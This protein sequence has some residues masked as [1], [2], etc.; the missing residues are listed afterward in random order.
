[1]AGKKD[2][3][4]SARIAEL[5]NDLQ[6]TRADFENYRKQMDARNAQTATYARL[7]I[8]KKFLPLLD[9]MARAIAVTPDLKPLEK[10]LEKT[11]KDLGL[12]KID[13]KP[14]TPFNPDLHDAVMMN[15]GEGDQ[16]VVEE[17]LRDG[18]L[19]EGETLRPAMVKVTTK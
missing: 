18:Y 5:T 12:T 14:G 6:R 1:M 19:Y 13:A 4:N 15:D 10:T 16:E 2:D 3:T 8:V 11:L 9:D 7:E 17:V